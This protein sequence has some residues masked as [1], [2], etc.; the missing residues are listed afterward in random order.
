MSQGT[1]QT[2]VRHMENKEIRHTF[3]LKRKTM[4]ELNKIKKSGQSWDFLFEYL[5]EC[6]WYRKEQIKPKK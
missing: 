6:Y 5:V 3:R 2:N 4:A 1:G